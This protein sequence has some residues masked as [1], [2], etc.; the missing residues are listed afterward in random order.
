MFDEDFKDR[1]GYAQK[2]IVECLKEE[3]VKVF[4]RFKDFKTPT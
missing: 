1:L 4:E 2:F 3:F